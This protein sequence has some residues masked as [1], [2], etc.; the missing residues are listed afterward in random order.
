MKRIFILALLSA[1]FTGSALAQGEMDAFNLSYNGLK[2]TARS[3]AMG[4]AFGALGGD[5]SGIAIN[6]AG[7][8]VYTTSEVVTTLN[9]TNTR[10]KTDL[11]GSRTDDSKFKFSFDNLAFVGTVPLHSDVAPLINFGF[12]YNRLQSFDRRYTMHGNFL[13]QSQTQYIANRVEGIPS[14]DLELSQ[15]PFF[16]RSSDY[17]LGALAYNTGMISPTVPGGNGDRYESVIKTMND[18]TVDN[19]L[20]VFERGSIDSYDFNM[21]TTFAD[22]LSAG[23]SVS[24]TDISYNV[25]TLYSEDLYEGQNTNPAHFYDFDNQLRTDGSGWQVKAGLIFKPIQ[26]LRIGVAY[27]SPTWYN[28][29]DSYTV[30]MD[31][32]S[33]TVSSRAEEGVVFSDYKFRTPDKWVFSLAGIIAQRAIISA[34]YELTNYASMNLQDRN[35]FGLSANQD[36]KEDFRSSSTLRVGGEFRITPQFSGRVGYMWQ[37][38]PV[39]DILRNG[40]ANGT[41]TAATAGTITNYS[42]V[43]NAN[44]FTYGLGYRFTPQFYTDVAFV[45]QNRTDDLYTHG[46]SDKTELKNNMFSG[47][48]TIGYRF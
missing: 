44:Y 19:F 20:H 27:H 5:I 10:T 29:T 15:D 26:E 13:N 4:G 35:G 46:G 8:G 34:D 33:T 38:S 12:S 24:V 36:I 31:N 47:L 42:L 32:G 11:Y 22:M 48:L 37:Q 45:M 23:L 2:G 1:S 3:V 28:M 25:T 40:S 9:F 16:D 18:P 14:R 17:W 43:G 21:G 39:K 30:L 6:P 41:H 7:I